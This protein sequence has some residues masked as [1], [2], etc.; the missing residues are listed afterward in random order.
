MIHNLV[1][2]TLIGLGIDVNRFR[3]C[4]TTPIEVAVPLA[5]LVV[6]LY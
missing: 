5:S 1:V 6:E 4:P 2:N 3:F